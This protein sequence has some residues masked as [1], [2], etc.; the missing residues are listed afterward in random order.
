MKKKEIKR[1]TIVIVVLILSITIF[2]GCTSTADVVGKYEGDPHFRAVLQLNSDKTGS[3]SDGFIYAN[4]TWRVSGNTLY[5][6]VT[7]AKEAFGEEMTLY[8][9][10]SG[11]TDRIILKS[12]SN[13]WEE[14]AYKKI[15]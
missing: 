13:Y 7:D 11:G 6:D 10:L 2:N 14:G 5:I 12:E 3:L 15:S 1:I 4:L 9:D 8:A